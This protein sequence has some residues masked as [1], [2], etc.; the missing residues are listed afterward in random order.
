MISSPER[1]PAGDILT[2]SVIKY[3]TVDI[4][5]FAIYEE[6]CYLGG[7]ILYHVTAQ[8]RFL[9]LACYFSACII[10]KPSQGVYIIWKVLLQGVSHSGLPAPFPSFTSLRPRMISRKLLL[11][12][13]SEKGNQDKFC[14]SFGFFVIWLPRRKPLTAR[15]AACQ[16]LPRAPF[17]PD[18][19]EKRLARRL[20]N[21][22]SVKA[23]RQDPGNVGSFPS[24]AAGCLHD[25]GQVTYS[26]KEGMWVDDLP[27][28][29]GSW[30]HVLFASVSHL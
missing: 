16:A 10:R 6:F 22:F 19:R 14:R 24:P 12:Q 29:K 13:L 5:P 30:L 7:L 9:A 8:Y 20:E 25:P 18:A 3:N 28:L 21:G 23:L 11:S 27:V 1:L 26:C 15:L 4:S 2:E 17:L